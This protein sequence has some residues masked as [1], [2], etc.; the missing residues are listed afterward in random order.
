MK[1]RTRL[2]KEAEARHE[3]ELRELRVQLEAATK[4]NTALRKQVEARRGI[5]VEHSD[6]CDA[7]G[8][9]WLQK[10]WTLADGIRARVAHLRAKVA[11]LETDLTFSRMAQMSPD[12][13]VEAWKRICAARQAV[14]PFDQL[15][16]GLDALLGDLREGLAAEP[17][18]IEMLA[19]LLEQVRGEGT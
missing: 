5:A 1:R 16:D 13:K 12:E 9:A 8:I 18:Q 17:E 3:A 2:A 10:G 4:S 15:C 11:M 7:L 6:A 19:G 14:D